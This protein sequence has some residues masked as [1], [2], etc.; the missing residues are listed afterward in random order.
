MHPTMIRIPTKD[1]QVYDWKSPLMAYIESYYDGQGLASAGKN[2]ASDRCE[3]LDQLRQDMH[4]SICELCRYLHQ[5]E[6][7]DLRFPLEDN[8]IRVPFIW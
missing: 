2:A 5:L 7:L 8:V 4:K 1:T 3:R 6:L